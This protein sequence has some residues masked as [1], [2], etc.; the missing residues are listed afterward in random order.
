MINRDELIRLFKEL[1]P[2]TQLKVWNQFV[3]ENDGDEIGV[4]YGQD[5]VDSQEC[6]WEYRR[7]VYHDN[8]GE[9]FEDIWEVEVAKTIQH[10]KNYCFKHKYVRYYYDTSIDEWILESSDNVL[11]LIVK[12]YGVPMYEQDVFVV[13]FGKYV[14]NKLNGKGE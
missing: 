6:F 7:E 8:N 14:M 11:D 13:W 3:F 1:N 10:S 9:G 4:Y 2:A 12:K 5:T